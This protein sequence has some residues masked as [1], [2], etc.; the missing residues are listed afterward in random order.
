MEPEGSLPHSQELAAYPYF[1][2]HQSCPCPHP[3]SWRYI[4]ILSSH[5]RLCLPRGLFL[6]GFPTKTLYAPLLSPPTCCMP[7]PPPSWFVYPNNIWWGYRTL[8]LKGSGYSF[9]VPALISEKYVCAFCMV[10]WINLAYFP[11]E[12][13][14]LCCYSGYPCFMYGVFFAWILCFKW[15]KCS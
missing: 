1:E 2:P 15:E 9:G 10:L 7:L 8:D 13:L 3:T 5:L 12:H 6:S 14:A 11:E 4:L